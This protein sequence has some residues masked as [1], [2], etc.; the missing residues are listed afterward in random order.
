MKR[1]IEKTKNVLMGLACIVILY[2]WTVIMFI[3][4]DA[5]FKKKKKRSEKIRKVL[6]LVAEFRKIKER[7][8]PRG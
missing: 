2:I 7:W 8:V 5:Q 6:T 4:D 3:L 1:A